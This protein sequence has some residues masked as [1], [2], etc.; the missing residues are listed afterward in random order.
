M[1]TAIAV[2]IATYSDREIMILAK[3]ALLLRASARE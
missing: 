2:A 1:K 3:T